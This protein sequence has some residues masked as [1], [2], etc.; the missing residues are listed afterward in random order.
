M[1][2]NFWKINKKGYRLLLIGKIDKNKIGKYASKI[3]SEDIVLTNER[4]IHIFRNHQNDYNVIMKNIARIIENPDEVLEDN[5]NKD[6]LFF[7]G[8]LNKNNL[9]IVIKL[10]TTNSKEHPNNSIMTAW[11]IREKNLKKA[12]E[13]NNTIYKME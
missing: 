4:R 8:K 1:W 3:K 5:K 10:N 2:Y 12:R 7:I 11:I 6:T 13:K 9:N